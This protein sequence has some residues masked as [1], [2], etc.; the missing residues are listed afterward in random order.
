MRLKLL[1]S[2]L[3][4]GILAALAPGSAGAFCGF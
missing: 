4:A 1:L 2:A 3:F